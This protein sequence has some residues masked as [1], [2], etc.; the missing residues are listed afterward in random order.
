MPTATGMSYLKTEEYASQ[1][2]EKTTSQAAFLAI[3]LSNIIPTTA[4]SQV[5]ARRI[6]QIFCW[7]KRAEAG[8]LIAQGSMNLKII[9]G[10]NQAPET[11]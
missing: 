2:G 8:L 3:L 4:Q 6:H 5:P 11:A 10:T 7:S 9:D 1:I